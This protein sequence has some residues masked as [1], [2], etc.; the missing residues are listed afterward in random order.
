MLRYRFAEPAEAVKRSILFHRIHADLLLFSL[1]SSRLA[2]RCHKENRRNLPD[3]L[4]AALRFGTNGLLNCL[5]KQYSWLA[6]GLEVYQRRHACRPALRPRF[7]HLG[8]EAV[9][10][11]RKAMKTAVVAGTVST[12]TKWRRQGLPTP[13]QFS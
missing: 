8:E 5:P 4:V 13:N 9:F 3:S 12:S 6:S 2:E 11:S 10:S 7:Q 1:G